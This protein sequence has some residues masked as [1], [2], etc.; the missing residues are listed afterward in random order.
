MLQA[1]LHLR[2]AP[3]TKLAPAPCVYYQK[4]PG[5]VEWVYWTLQ[6]TATHC[7]TLQHT[8]THCN[9]LRHT[10]THCNSGVLVLQ[11]VYYQKS[12]LHQHSHSKYCFSH[13]MPWYAARKMPSQTEYIL[14]SK[15]YENIPFWYTIYSHDFLLGGRGEDAALKRVTIHR[16]RLICVSTL[17][18]WKKKTVKLLI[19]DHTEKF[20][21]TCCRQNHKFQNARLMYAHVQTHAHTH[22]AKHKVK[23]YTRTTHILHYIQYIILR[24]TGS[25]LIIK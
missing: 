22:K 12:H 1:S 9:T 20:S 24:K 17:H 6:H 5:L 15:R 14:E 23:I 11:C 3:I 7:N 10:A 13:C 19:H 4:S 8:A 18:E 21:S 25:G 2:L 16:L